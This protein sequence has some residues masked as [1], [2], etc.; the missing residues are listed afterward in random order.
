MRAALKPLY[1]YQWEL[2]LAGAQLDEKILRCP[3]S[4]NVEAAIRGHCRSLIMTASDIKYELISLEQALSETDEDS[5]SETEKAGLLAE[6]LQQMERSLYLV[7]K[8]FVNLMASVE[9]QPEEEAAREILKEFWPKM[10]EI[11]QYFKTS[12]LEV[13]AENK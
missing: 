11:Y 8:N 12:L 13:E 9:G 7:V 1:D 10:A 5:L 6:A 2:T 3:C 4:G